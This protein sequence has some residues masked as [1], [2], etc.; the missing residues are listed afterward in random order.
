[1][2]RSRLIV[3][4]NLS[5]VI[6][7]SEFVRAECGR[8]GIDTDDI[9]S[10]DQCVVE[11]VTNVIKHAYLGKPGNP[12]SIE[13]SATTERL[14]LYVRDQGLTMPQ[15]DVARLLNGS[16]VLN[17]DPLDLGS[18]PEQGMGLEII[19]QLIDEAAYL[20]EGGANCLRLTKFLRRSETVATR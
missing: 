19:H 10:V 15:E 6:L 13:L 14:D 5:N 1:M 12:V 18:V 9:S 11:A 2:G 20:A 16:P 8:K 3:D 17:F 4:S 7:I